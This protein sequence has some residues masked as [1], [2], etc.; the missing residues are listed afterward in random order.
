MVFAFHAQR[1]WS[2]ASNQPLLLLLAHAG[3]VPTTQMHIKNFNTRV[4]YMASKAKPKKVSLRTLETGEQVFFLCKQAS[5]GAQG[6]QR[7]LLFLLL[8][9][10]SSVLGNEVSPR[11]LVCLSV[12]SVPVLSAFAL[13]RVMCVLTETCGSKISKP[14]CKQIQCI[15]PEGGAGRAAQSAC[16]CSPCRFSS[17]SAFCLFVS[18]SSLAPDGSVEPVHV[19]R[20]A[21]VPTSR[22]DKMA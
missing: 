17:L 10:L 1:F 21:M 9:F 15:H 7:R 8:I 6:V 18:K 12:L 5:S 14:I 16:S 22:G 11:G 3:F 20:A 2:R 13:V 19:A 4:R